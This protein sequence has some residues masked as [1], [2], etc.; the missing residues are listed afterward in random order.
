MQA[1]RYVCR[2][3][4]LILILLLVAPVRA[5]AQYLYLDLNGD[6]LNTPTDILSGTL[7]VNVDIYLRTDRNR[8]GT[9][10]TCAS[11]AQPLSIGSLEFILRAVGGS[12]TWGTL[13]GAGLFGNGATKTVHNATDFYAGYFDSTEQFLPPGRYRLG[14]LPVTPLAGTPLLTFATTTALSAHYSTSFGSQCRGPGDADYTMRLGR[15][16]SDADGTFGT[17]LANVSGKVF[18]DSNGTSSG[19]CVLDPGEVGVAGWPVTLSPTGPTILTEHDGSFRFQNVPPGLYS[20]HLSTPSAW[21]QTC[22]SGGANRSLLVALGQAYGNLN[23]GVKPAN[24]PPSLSPISNR[25]IAQGSIVNV[26]LSASDPDATPL[27]FSLVTGPA[28]AS[29]Q[30]TSATTGNLRLTPSASDAGIHG[31]TVAASDGTY[32]SRRSALVRV[33][34][35]AG[36]S[37]VG[38]PGKF[39]AS[40]QPNPMNPAGT[41]IF[42]TSRRGAIHAV[43]YDAE[44]RV[45]RTLMNA[46]TAPAKQYRLIVGRDDHGRPLAS[47][48]YFFKVE[49]IDGVQSGR[50]VVMK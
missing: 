6:G 8:D 29:V 19:D 2:L 17:I 34:T 36:G 18:Q 13:T 4:F 1:L 16:W 22:P 11:G 40:I 23:F 38:G 39:Q 9:P 27:S 3:R 24:L 20:I 7:P 50:A 49:T 48:V 44:G 14:T 43:L 15:E 42:R 41:L 46:T 45:V 31:L 10:T 33:L 35:A 5:G 32:D 37:S 21:N 12:V 26:P 25:T 47:G 28:F 30:T